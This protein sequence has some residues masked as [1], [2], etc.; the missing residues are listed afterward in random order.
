MKAWVLEGDR[1]TSPIIVAILDDHQSIIDGYL[2][3]LAQ[4][5]DIQVVGT[6]RFGEELETLLNEHS[7]DVLILDISV[8]NSAQDNNLFPILSTLPRLLHHHR[9]LKILAISMLTQPALVEALVEAGVRGYVFKDDQL[10]IQQLP[11]IIRLIGSGSTYFSPGAY[12]GPRLDKSKLQ[13]T[14]CQLEA[15]TICAALPNS[16]SAI[17]AEKMG[18][19][20]SSFRNLMSGTY[21]R[22]GVQTRLAAITKAI[23]LGYLPDRTRQFSVRE[24]L[25]PPDV[26]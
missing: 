23:Q 18:I 5:S 7:V 4:I 22:L 14:P 19:S 26:D 10:S 9:Q 6:I 17:L 13:I 15:L 16:D 24:D 1:M 21:Q 25:P 20:P 2:Y 11:K 3:R 8:P 12:Q